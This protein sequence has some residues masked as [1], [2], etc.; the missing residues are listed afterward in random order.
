MLRNGIPEKTWSKLLYSDFWEKPVSEW[1]GV[2]NWELYYNKKNPTKKTVQSSHNS[3]RLELEA[4]IKYGD[5]RT[6]AWKKAYAMSNELKLVLLEYISSVGVLHPALLVWERRVFGLVLAIHHHTC[7]F[8]CATPC[9]ACVG[10]KSVWSPNKN[11]VDKRPC[12][13]SSQSPEGSNMVRTESINNKYDT[14]IKAI[15]IIQ[16]DNNAAYINPLWWGVLDFREENIHPAPNHLRVKN[17]LPENEINRHKD[18]IKN[19]V[20]E[21]KGKISKS[22]NSFFEILLLCDTVNLQLLAKEYGARGV[23]GICNL[24][25]RT[26]DEIEDDNKQI[27]VQDHLENVDPDDDDTIYIGKCIQDADVWIRCFHGKCYSERT[28]DMFLIGPFSKTPNTLFTYG[29]NHSSADREDKAKRSGTDR[30]GKACDFLYWSMDREVGVGEN[31]GP[32]HREN[33]DKVKTNFI[34]VIKVSKAQHLELKAQLIEQSGINPL[35]E[36]LQNALESIVIPFFQII[37]MQI[38]FYI[39]FQ[40]NGDL[41]GFWDW[42]SEKLPT[43]NEDVNELVLLCKQFL[44]Y[45]NLVDRVGRT[46]EICEKKAKDFKYKITEES[47]Q[48]TT[49]KTVHLDKFQTPVRPSRSQALIQRRSEIASEKQVDPESNAVSRILNMEVRAQLPADTSDALLWKRIE[50]AKKLWKLF[51]AIGMDKIYRIH[52]FSVSSISKMTYEDIQYIIDN[53][54][55]DYSIKIESS[56]CAQPKDTLL[57]DEKNSELSHPDLGSGSDKKNSELSHTNTSEEQTS[58]KSGRM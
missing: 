32:S 39:L 21:E 35:P 5:K 33:H 4:L 42:A 57:S 20:L 25:K 46:A 13:T 1:G 51:D 12:R 38:R 52:S 11:I 43:K 7:T 16:S 9:S 22:A 53:M 41:Y 24:F 56:T 23:A 2:E 8:Y 3:L 48:I 19:I 30:T 54:P 18:M 15:K 26:V 31:S 14:V 49:I 10:K 36:D 34:D 58:S 29:E 40:I 28:I 44:I 17:F 55:V 37:A 47:S 27:T 6:K 45:G 50:Q